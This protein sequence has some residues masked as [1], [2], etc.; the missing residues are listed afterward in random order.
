MCGISCILTLSHPSRS[1]SHA[2]SNGNGTHTNGNGT[3]S[4]HDKHDKLKT[5]LYASL[6]AIRHRGP[7]GTGHWISDDC[8]VGTLVYLSSLSSHPTLHSD[9]I[10][11]STNI[12]TNNSNPI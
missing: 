11:T 4:N 2:Q 5:E 12:I 3:T 10:S 8:R 6:E 1:H 7:D 9:P